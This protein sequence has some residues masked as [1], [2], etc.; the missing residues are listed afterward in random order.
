MKQ[1]KGSAHVPEIMLHTIFCLSSSSLCLAARLGSLWNAAMTLC[2]LSHVLVPGGCSD[3]FASM[4]LEN[5][6][7]SWR[8]FGLCLSLAPVAEAQVAKAPHASSSAKSSK[9][10]EVPLNLQL[11]Q[12]LCIETPVTNG[13]GGA[14]CAGVLCHG[15]DGSL[16]HLSED[17]PPAPCTFKRGRSCFFAQP[18]PADS[19]QRCKAHHQRDGAVELFALQRPPT[20]HSR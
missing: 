5:L 6:K 12:P 17:L 20:F 11:I 15:R 16:H 14:A 19:Q 9:T 1:A 2:N 13:P 3:S 18:R 8:Q 10:K 7:A 4:I